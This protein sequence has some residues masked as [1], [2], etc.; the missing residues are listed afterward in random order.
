MA[1]NLYDRTGRSAPVGGPHDLQDPE[2]LKHRGAA[3][4]P[5]PGSLVGNHS[6]EGFLPARPVAWAPV[7]L[8]DLE[9]LKLRGVS[10]AAELQATFGAVVHLDAT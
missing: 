8:P 9:H 7:G 3:A 4:A 1:G 2:Q 5:A 10:G 6:R